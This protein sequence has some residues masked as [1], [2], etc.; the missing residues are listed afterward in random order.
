[1]TPQKAFQKIV[2][3]TIG[4]LAKSENNNCY[5]VTMMCDLTKFLISAP[6][7]S[8]HA[9]EVAKAIFHNLILIYGPV[10]EILTDCGSEYLNQILKELL[11]LYDINHVHSTPYRHQTVGT[12]ERNHRNFNEYLRSYMDNISNWEEY[13]R[14]FNYCYNTTPNT[15][16]N[17]KYSPYELVFGKKPNNIPFLE[18]NTIDPIYNLDN[19]ALETKYKLQNAQKLASHLLNKMKQTNKNTFDKNIRPINLNINDQIVVIN[20]TGH[21]HESIYKGPYTVTKIMDPNIEILDKL[22]NKSKILHKNNIRKY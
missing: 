8:K 13:L 15:C 6:V 18:E 19:Y 4:P 9:K 11:S 17:T 14:Y 21:K 2:I 10:S 3:D 22:T 7:P 5:I 16:F 12:V 20:E 1:M